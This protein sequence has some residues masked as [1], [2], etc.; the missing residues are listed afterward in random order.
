MDVVIDYLGTQYVVELKYGEAMPTTSEAKNS[1]AATL[2]TS[3][4]RLATSSV[5]VSTR[6]KYL[7]CSHQ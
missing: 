4:S 5:S 2:S 1:S 7:V 3:I 6:P